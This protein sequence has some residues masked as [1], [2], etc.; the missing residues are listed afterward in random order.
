MNINGKVVVITGATAGIGK[1]AGELFRACGATVYSLAR[2][3]SETFKSIQ[4]D[5]TDR[6]SVA[7]ALKRVFEEEGKIDIVV[8]NAGFGISG[9]IEDTAESSARSIFDVNVFGALNVMQLAVPYLREGGGGKIINISSAATTFPIP[10]QGLY[11][12]TKAALSSLSDA[13]RIEVAPF[14]IKVSCVLPGDVKTE[15]TAARQK[16]EV[17]GGFYGERISRSVAV[18][19]RDEQNGLP[20]EV[21][22][23]CILKL[24]K[25]NNPPA[26]VVGGGKYK[27]LAAA[28]KVMPKRFVLFLIAKLYG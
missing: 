7:S 12:A 11:S 6:A 20:P 28:A 13:L 14:G 3:Q 2:R 19:E 21:I 24:A 25:K 4:T 18:M 1:S 8:N 16:N 15:F 22:A 26:T 5:V 9:A 23:K 17:D 10:F 27:L